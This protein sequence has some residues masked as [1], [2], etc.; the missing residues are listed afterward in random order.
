MGLQLHRIALRLSGGRPDLRLLQGGAKGRHREPGTDHLAARRG[1]SLWPAHAVGRSAGCTRSASTGPLRSSG[2][3]QV[4]A[5]FHKGG[6]VDRVAPCQAPAGRALDRRRFSLSE[7]RGAPTTGNRDYRGSAA[8]APAA[9]SPT[10]I[11]RSITVPIGA[12]RVTRLLQ[13]SP[14]A[15]K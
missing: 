3:R 7:N 15:G 10:S 14:R 9:S 12:T 5:G 6:G 1:G 8:K 13:R 11:A 2:G 4:L